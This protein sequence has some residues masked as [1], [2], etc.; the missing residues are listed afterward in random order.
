MQEIC[1]DSGLKKYFNIV[2]PSQMA[3]NISK[4]LDDG[5]QGPLLMLKF[6]F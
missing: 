1:C 6:K 4:I 3:Y 5:L 2:D